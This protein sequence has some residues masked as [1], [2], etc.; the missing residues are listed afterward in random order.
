MDRS[1]VMVFE[2]IHFFLC[3]L[4]FWKQ[5]AMISALLI[6]I[7]ALKFSKAPTMPKSKYIVLGQWFF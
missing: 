6:E 2:C 3:R 5:F 1:F 4:F 7:Y